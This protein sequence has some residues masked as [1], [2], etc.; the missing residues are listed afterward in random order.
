MF[1]NFTFRDLT[2]DMR[3]ILKHWQD[4]KFEFD[5]IYT[6]YLGSFEQ[7]N[8]VKEYFTALKTENCVTV[9]DPVMADNGQ[10]YP[11]FTVEFA[12]EMGT[13]CAISDYI[14]PNLTEACIMLDKEYIEKGYS[15]EYIKDI[16]ISLAS[17]GAKTA[18]LTGVSFEEGKTGVM[19]YDSQ[20]K[21][22]FE[23]YHN[24][25]NASY[26]GTGDIFS[27]TFVGAL[28]KGKNVLDALKIACDYTAKCVEITVNNPNSVKYG[29]E[30]ENA[31]PYL[32]KKLENE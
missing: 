27:S 4:E 6:G 11:G 13:L 24:R 8:L 9:V 23:Y 15:R 22:F 19:G 28:T 3:P 12:K 25:I 17:L 1:K 30:F 32:V 7:I 10:L 21:E 16:L 14:V 26:H 31:I 2:C 29:V 20:T 18:I 5:A